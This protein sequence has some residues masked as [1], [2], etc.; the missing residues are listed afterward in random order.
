VVAAG[1]R[2]EH[3]GERGASLDGLENELENIHPRICPTAVQCRGCKIEADTALILLVN[4]L[5]DPVS[6]GIKKVAM[7]LCLHGILI[8]RFDGTETF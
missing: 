6:R 5:L 4:F 3:F 7:Y 8:V 1:H 2:R